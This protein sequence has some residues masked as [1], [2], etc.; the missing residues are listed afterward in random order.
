MRKINILFLFI[1]MICPLQMRAQTA[2]QFTSDEGLSNSCVRR[3]YEDSRRNVWICTRNGLNRYDGAKV[4]VYH[5]DEADPHS[6]GHDLVTYILEMDRDHILVGHDTGLQSFS[7]AE[8]SFV[9]IPLIVESGDTVGQTHVV[10]LSKFL[11]GEMHVCATGN[12]SFIIRKDASGNLYGEQIKTYSYNEERPGFLL[13][14][15]DDEVWSVSSMRQIVHYKGKKAQVFNEVS[16]VKRLCQG[17]DKCIYAATGTNGIYKYDEHKHSFVKLQTNGQLDNV[18]IK[19][20]RS[21][22]KGR[23]MIC[24]DGNGLKFYD[25]KTGVVT[26]SNI[27]TTDFN[28]GNSNVEDAMLDSDGNL[29]VGVYWKGVIVQPRVSSIFE[30]VGRR[31][32]TKNT[33]GANS[34]I[35]VLPSKN[36]GVW[37]ATDNTGLYRISDDGTQSQHW[38]PV[39]N[40]GVPASI[41]AMYEDNKGNLWLGSSIGGLVCMNINSGT[42]TPFASINSGGKEVQQIFDISEDDAHNIW[43][44]CMG[45]GVFRYNL[46]TNL[47]EQYTYGSSG[48]KNAI[49]HNP[50]ISCVLPVGKTLYVCSADGVDVLSKK[51]DGTYEHKKQILGAATVNDARAAKD[52]TVWFATSRGLFCLHVDGTLKNYTVADG[53]PDNHVSSVQLVEDGKILQ[54]LWIGTDKGLCCIDPSRG[55]INSFFISDGLQ[56]N[57]FCNHSSAQ[58][59]GIFYFGGINGLNYFNPNK[60]DQGYAARMINFRIVDFY[61]L[62]SPVHVGQKS[63]S[64]DILTDWISEAKE[65]N[66]CHSDNSFSIEM[67]SMNLIASHTAYEYSVNNGEWISLGEGQNRVSFTNMSPGSYFIRVRAV[68]YSQQSEEKCIKVIV[69]PAWYDSPLAYIIYFILLLAIG[70]FVYAQVK[71]RMAARRVLMTHRQEEELNEARIQFFMNISHE[72]R[73]PM[74]LILAPLE[75]LRA[76]DADEEHQRNYKL[77]YQNAHRIL[78]LI[79][80]LMDVRKIEKG[81]FQLDYKKIDIVE[82]VNSLY[83]VYETSAKNRG[84]DF[85]FVHNGIDNLEAMVDTSSFDKIVMNLLSNAFKFTPDDGKITIQLVKNDNDTF[86]LR[87]VDTGVGIKD[88]EKQKVFT[89]FYSAKHQNGYVGTGIGLNL[90]ALLVELHNGDIKVV[91]NPSGQGV[92]FVINMPINASATQENVQDSIADADVLKAEQD[93]LHSHED[94]QETVLPVDKVATKHRNLLVVEDD[95][96]IRQYIHSEL[97]SDFSI[98]ECSNGMEAWSFVQK[99]PEKVDLIISDIMMPVMEGTSLC[100][101]VKNNFNTNHIPVILMSAKTSEADRI[102]GISIGADAYV[103]KPFNVELLRTTALN[104][105]RQRQTLRGKYTAAMKQEGSIEQIELTSPDEHLMERVMKVINANID[106]SDLS[107]ELVADKVGVSRVH[108]HRKIKELTGQTPRDFIKSI[109]LKEAARLLSEKHLDIT[110]V[111]VATGFKSLSTFSTSFKQVYGQTPTEYMN[112]RNKLERK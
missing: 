97:S 85:Q 27:R 82:F 69:H 25:E 111:S 80:Q 35:S 72:I 105:L 11:N 93:E 107:V 48:N 99:N 1:L 28:L 38:D 15:K 30:Y 109:R 24:T 33:I 77:I 58:R 101:N 21:D 53:I 95:I 18:V 10:S 90:T 36:G 61:L 67:S 62:G 89:R 6:L 81:Q 92:C 55:M 63:G 22:G 12:R 68:G 78:R 73:T 71:E 104:I 84:I 76:M 60:I 56:G 57:E 32:P 83:D 64:Y 26:Q 74:T 102:A 29:W 2:I 20:I 103:T 52:G 13:N 5:H 66:L 49:L 3:I 106:N 39:A 14:T 47:L 108:F 50:W 110:D 17:T 4:N 100:Q 94:L 70:F 91:D 87:V 23:L 9:N 8:N 75:K 43:I 112:E 16:D 98:Q 65:V 42:F 31:S 40:P 88:D 86:T 34:V 37:V 7:Y 79:N 19:S 59:N 51:S 46:E 45:N 54:A 44:A 96:A 41:G